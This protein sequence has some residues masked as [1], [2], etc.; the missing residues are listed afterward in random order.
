MLTRRGRQRWIEELMLSRVHRPSPP[1]PP[2]D[3][4][5]KPPGGGTWLRLVYVTA[6]G[7]APGAVSTRMMK[8]SNS[9]SEAKCVACPDTTCSTR[10]HSWPGATAVSAYNCTTNARSA[11]SRGSSLEC[12]CMEAPDCGMV[13]VPTSRRCNHYTT[14]GVASLKQFLRFR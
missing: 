10:Q 11:G 14:G 8:P 6:R 7:Y 13:T 12:S 1:L 2:A 9:A 3:R 5:N 4:E